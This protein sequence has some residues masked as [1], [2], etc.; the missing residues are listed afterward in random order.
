M[1]LRGSGGGKWGGVI[2]VSDKVKETSLEAVEG[3][4]SRGLEV[5]LLTG[6]SE[7]VAKHVGEALGI[8]I[9]YGGVTPSEKGV[10]V[11]E[12]REGGKRVLMVGDGVN[13]APALSVADVGMAMGT[14]TDIAMESA[15]MTLLHGDLRGV[16][17]AIELSEAVMRNIRQNLFFAFVYNVLGVFVASGIFY[18][19]WGF[20]LSPMFAA[21]AMSLSSVSVMM[22]A[23]RLRFLRL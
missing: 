12:L 4:K 9:F 22:N 18:F 20:L 1:S 3:L 13:D 14:G 6:D 10:R 8:D 21:F 17:K 19:L 2:W 5:V 16:L 23:L 7:E 15:G 11:R